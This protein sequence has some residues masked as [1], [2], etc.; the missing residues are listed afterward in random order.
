M[1]D[2]TATAGPRLHRATSAWKGVA[3]GVARAR[4]RRR[5]R[6][7]EIEI[8]RDLEVDDATL[9]RLRW[10]LS[11][12]RRRH[13]KFV[14]CASCSPGVRV[15]FPTSSASRTSTAHRCS[16]V[17]AATATKCKVDPLPW[18]ATTTTWLRSRL[19][20]GIGRSRPQSSARRPPRRAGRHADR[21]RH[22]RDHGR[23]GGVRG[24][25]GGHVRSIR[26]AGGGPVAG[27]LLFCTIGHVQHSV[28]AVRL[29]CAISVE[30]CVVVD[31]HCRPSVEHVFAAGDMKLVRTSCRWLR[32][33]QPLPASPPRSPCA[34]S[35]AVPSSPQP[36]RDPDQDLERAA[37]SV[38]ILNR[39]GASSRSR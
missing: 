16:P 5:G 8:E 1:V 25:G 39:D 28:L 6:Y 18:S 7:P 2:S 23:A 38:A 4:T 21:C 31:D 19:A 33:T 22:Q 35:G 24:R 36:A 12:A 20:C 26:L 29:G 37:S 3:S 9:S 34:V 14:L 27:E 10:V 15:S 30:G 17:R 32:T 11:T 13:P